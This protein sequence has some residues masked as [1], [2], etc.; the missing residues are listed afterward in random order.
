[1][2]KE[3]RKRLDLLFELDTIKAPLMQYIAPKVSLK[4]VVDLGAKD[5]NGN[6]RRFYE[7]I[8][9]K[10][11]KYNNIDH[12]ISANFRIN[13]YLVLEYPNPKYNPNIDTGEMKNSGIILR[14]YSIDELVTK[15]KYFNDKILN[16]C[17]GRNDKGEIIIFSD[18]ARMMN[19]YIG[20]MSNGS[21][22]KLMPAIYY[23][24]DEI[25]N[26]RG[27]SGV[28][29]DLNGEYQFTIDTDSTWM[30]LIYRLSHCDLTMLGFQMIQPFMS[31][32]PGNAVSEIG[33]KYDPSARYTPYY[34]VEDPD[35]ICNSSDS[36]MVRESKNSNES[37]KHIFD[38]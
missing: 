38:Y 34:S 28:T 14:G 3:E 36:V 5:I 10:S 32:L 29:L 12:L 30:E 15:M 33:A 23:Y 13:T 20:N 22:I 21:W 16:H 26:R 24:N 27:T 35:D 1:M 19:I 4:V 25:G 18:K 8:R 9:Y 37:K 31:L 11:D 2:T 6:K 17:F 7:E